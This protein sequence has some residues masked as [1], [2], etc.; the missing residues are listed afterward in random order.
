MLPCLPPLL[1]DRD[2]AEEDELR[3]LPLPLRLLLLLLRLLLRPLAEGCPA[4]AATGASEG[5]PLLPNPSPEGI[6]G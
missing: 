6:M 5:M 1:E 3:L 2:E 4:T